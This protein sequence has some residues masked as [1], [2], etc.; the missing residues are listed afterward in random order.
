MSQNASSTPSDVL[1]NSSNGVDAVSPCNDPSCHERSESW[2]EWFRKR[3]RISILPP[4]RVEI[5][6]AGWLIVHTVAA[7][8]P[9]TPTEEEKV[10]MKAWLRSFAYLYPCHIC[11]SGFIKV[12]ERLP[13]DTNN[14][15]DLTMWACNAHNQVNADIGIPE[16]QCDLVKLLAFFGKQT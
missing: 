9:L 6:R 15:N 5:G 1:K 12:I 7:Q 13:P 2:L 10:R 11:R 16:Y 14:R 4:D 3:S 8:F